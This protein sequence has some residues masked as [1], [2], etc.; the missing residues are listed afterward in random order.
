MSYD[1]FWFIDTRVQTRNLRRWLIWFILLFAFVTVGTYFAVK[2]MY[3][4]ITQYSIREGNPSITVNE[5]KATN[6]NGYIKGEVKNESDSELE[7]EYLCFILFDENYEIKGTEYIEIG[8][9]SA[10]ETKAYELKFKRDYIKHFYV[11]TIPKEVYEK[12]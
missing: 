8:K 3:T 2:T 5:A 7:G 1:D 4:D 11:L 9:L 10:G 12:I 6:V